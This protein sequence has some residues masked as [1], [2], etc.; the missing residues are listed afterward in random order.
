[1][2]IENEPALAAFLIAPVK[3]IAPGC[4]VGIHIVDY[5]GCLNGW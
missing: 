1:V 3:N 5:S 2:S 4:S